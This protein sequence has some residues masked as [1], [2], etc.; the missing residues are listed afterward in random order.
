MK[1]RI[2]LLLLCVGL[3]AAQTR[4]RSRISVYDLGSKTTRV[5]YTDDQV[6]EA[7]TWMPNGR[8]LLV[9]SGG[10][11]Y[12]L[13]VDGTDPRPD[14]LDV[15]GDMRCN[16]DK[17]ITRDGRMLAFSASSPSA[18]GSEVYVANADGSAR[19][20]VTNT[21][22]SYFH[23][24]SPDSRWMVVVAQ[25][26]KNFDLFRIPA[27]GGSELRLTSSPGYD[28]G[29]DYSADGK[30][31]YFNSDRSGSFHV[32]RMPPE[33]AGPDDAKAE[34]VTNDDVEDWFPHPSPNGK[35]LVFLSFPKGTHDHNGRTDVELRMMPLPGKKAGGAKPET[36]L[37]L[38]GGQGTININS[39]SPDSKRFAFVS[40]EVLP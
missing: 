21:P 29:P 24:W 36:V 38:F 1:F 16:N 25:R 10:A 39:W 27:T 32:W 3:G 15:G 23:G 9:N 33:G 22:P 28:D 31:I 5:I 13:A 20:Q 19:R 8:D 6:W 34:Q 7:P 18:P 4:Y 30:W 2:A 12:R 14:K 17:G 26:N 35:W 11:L 37:K 40:Y